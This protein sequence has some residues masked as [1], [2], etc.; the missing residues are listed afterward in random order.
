MSKYI[1]KEREEYKKEKQ[2]EIKDV[3]KKLEEG[4]KEVFESDRFKEYLNTMSKF[5]SYSPNNVLWILMQKPDATH[6][7]GFNKWKE[8][9]R[10]VKKGEKA[11]KVLAPIKHSK[12]V[13]IDKI[14]PITKKFIL[15]SN[16]DRVKELVKQDYLTYRVVPVFDIKQTEG[17]DLP[18]LVDE[19][20]GSINNYKILKESIEEVAKVPIE[21]IDI[22]DESKGYYSLDENNIKIKKGMDEKQTLKTL[23]HELTH[24]RLH[25][26]I[27]ALSDR[28]AAEVQAESV[29]FI[30]S[31][32]FEIDTSEYSFG[33]VAA[34]SMG[35][36]IT[37]LKKS[38]NIISK[39]SNKIIIELENAIEKNISKYRKID[40]L[41]DRSININKKSSIK[42]K[43]EH[44][45]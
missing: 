15:D 13:E 11:L 1:K 18:R 16:G 44:E 19:L 14:D 39:E 10:S 40:L 31:D 25:N 21:Y 42:T 30:V 27:E 34:W 33:Y 43:I 29:A 26:T 32:H 23:I 37:E 7:A 36:D 12:I 24:S 2:K 20:K 41:K 35:K 6:I 38:L 4:V 9:G 22:K 17:K 28:A 3:L 45:R 5:H 8:L